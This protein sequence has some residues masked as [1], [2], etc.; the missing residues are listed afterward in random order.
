MKATCRQ[1]GERGLAF[2]IV[3]DGYLR[4]ESNARGDVEGGQLLPLEHALIFCGARCVSLWIAAPG[5]RAAIDRMERRIRRWRPVAPK[6]R[7]ERR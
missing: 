4:F 3:L 7:R 1:C 2:G 5:S 6:R